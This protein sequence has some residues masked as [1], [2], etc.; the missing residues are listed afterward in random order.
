MLHGVVRHSLSY[1]FAVILCDYLIIRK[2][3]PYN[4]YHLYKSEGLYWYW[5]GCNPRALAAW[6]V[7]VTPLLPGLIYNINSNIKMGK[8][9]LEFYTLG[10]LDGLVIAS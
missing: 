1:L 10:W 8:G 5:K 6:M 2:A 4:M 3:K 9:I 7:G